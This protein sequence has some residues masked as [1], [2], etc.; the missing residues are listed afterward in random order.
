MSINLEIWIREFIEI[1]ETLFGS[2][3]LFTGLQGSYGRGEADEKSDID[4]VVILDRLTAD[5]LKAFDEAISKL[6]YRDKMCGFISGKQELLNWSKADL[7]QFYHDTM[8][9]V[10]EL[11]TLL[12]QLS[13]EDIRSAIQ[14]GACNIYHLCGHN[15]IHE[16][17]S[18]ILKS[19][20]KGSVFV[21]QA[22]YYYHTGIYI[23]KH[24]ELIT[25]AA[26]REQRLLRIYSDMK[27]NASSQKID[28]YGLS[29]ILFDWAGQ[30]IKEYG[31]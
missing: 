17:D 26:P 4:M 6:S 13:K 22:L 5:D 20:Y 15:I 18:D 25:K 9:I 1:V 7:F 8:P 12:P 3:L 27:E 31:K 10:G 24:K 28:F 14:S 11:R 30:I 21:A 16:K 19:L 29:E 2:R 23:K